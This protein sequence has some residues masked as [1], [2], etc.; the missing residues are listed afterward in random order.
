MK[1]I[2]LSKINSLLSQ[3]ILGLDFDS[4]IFRNLNLE[5]VIRL[6]TIS[7][8][9]FFSN[10][11]VNNTLDDYN[12]LCFHT[13]I[14]SHLLDTNKI[15]GFKSKWFK[16]VNYLNF[17]HSLIIFS[18]KECLIEFREILS[19]PKDCSV[20]LKISL[21]DE[22]KELGLILLSSNETFLDGKLYITVK[23]IS[24]KMIIINDNQHILNGQLLTR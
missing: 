1:S 24:N 23:N 9:N 6:D 8:D 5:E 12:T 18:N 19:N 2:T 4:S 3:N 22:L 10:A 13:N 15:S 16:L 21:T 20:S 17:K 11:Y 7:K 14:N